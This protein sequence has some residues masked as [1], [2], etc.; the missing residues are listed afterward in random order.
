MG[1]IVFGVLLMLN[2]MITALLDYYFEVH[3]EEE[4]YFAWQA[5][6]LNMTI[7]WEIYWDW[8]RTLKRLCRCKSRGPVKNW[9]GNVAH[10]HEHT[11]GH[12]F[13]WMHGREHNPDPYFLSTSEML[14]M[15]DEK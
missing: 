3:R 14:A 13:E 9:A 15:L 7:P 4:E 5:K 12:G 11:E 8:Q 1:V 2:V 10:K 6:H